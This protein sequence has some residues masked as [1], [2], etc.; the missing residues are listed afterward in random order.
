[1]ALLAPMS[2]GYTRRS[3]LTGAMAAVGTAAVAEAPLTSI[4]PMP[5]ADAGVV[6][7]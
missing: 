3:F 5:R 7:R 6:E 4:R 2:G 1:M